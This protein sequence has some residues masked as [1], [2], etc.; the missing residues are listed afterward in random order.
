MLIGL[1]TDVKC[2]KLVS[3]YVSCA[4]RFVGCMGWVGPYPLP[5][6]LCILLFWCWVE[7]NGFWKDCFDSIVFCCVLC[8]GR[9]LHPVAKSDFP[10]S[11]SDGSISESGLTI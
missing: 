4:V 9:G 10:V 3:T 6:G 5:V 1:R 11:E 8:G 7:V 2:L